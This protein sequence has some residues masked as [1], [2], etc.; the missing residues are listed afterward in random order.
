MTGNVAHSN[1]AGVILRAEPGGSSCS[2]LSNFTSWASWDFGLI[3]MKG[4]T[5]D[6]QLQHVVIAGALGLGCCMLAHSVAVNGCRSEGSLHWAVL[7]HVRRGWLSASCLAH[8]HMCVGDM[9]TAN[10][11]SLLLAIQHCNLQLC[12]C[13]L[14]S[15]PCR[16]AARRHSGPAQGSHD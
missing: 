6:L 14:C 8:V 9:V 2:R 7:E 11:S 4:I 15:L 12:R 10:R 16:H 13:A 5:S 1:L 3:T